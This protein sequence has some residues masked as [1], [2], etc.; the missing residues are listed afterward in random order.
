M[1]ILMIHCDSNCQSWSSWSLNVFMTTC[2]I[3]CP[4]WSSWS[5]VVFPPMWSSKSQW[6]SMMVLLIHD[7]LAGHCDPH[8]HWLSIHVTILTILIPN[9]LADPRWLCWSIE[10]IMIMIPDDTHAPPVIL[11]IQGCLP[12]PSWSYTH[13][14]IVMVVLQ[15]CWWSCR[16]VD[17]PAD[18]YVIMPICVC[19]PAD[20]WWHVG[21]LVL[22]Y[23]D[24]VWS[25]RYCKILLIWCDPANRVWSCKFVDDQSC[26]CVEHLEDLFAVLPM[27]WWSCR[28]VGGPVLQIICDPWDLL[29]I[30][31]ICCWSC[32]W[33][34]DPADKCV[35]SCRSVCDPADLPWSCR[36]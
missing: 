16:Y 32:R 18:M 6:W 11:K 23:T 7:G 25:D 31:H 1:Q 28:S 26:L 2:D 8:A 27:C 10:I 22:S 3:N 14:V 20:R 4:W 30:L 19:G 24:I 12:D 9:D 17:D 15:V 34:G 35:W 29:W 5:L 36:S 21:H 13:H 33:V